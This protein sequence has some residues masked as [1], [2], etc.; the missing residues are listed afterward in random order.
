MEYLYM[1]AALTAHDISLGSEIYDSGRRVVIIR[2]G[3]RVYG[4][5]V[6]KSIESLNKA[7]IQALEY[8]YNK[9]NSSVTK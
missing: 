3:R 4:S 9:L 7:W 2:N 5:K 6:Y 8:E 1:F